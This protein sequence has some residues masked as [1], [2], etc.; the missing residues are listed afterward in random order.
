MPP[1]ITYAIILI[2]FLTCCLSHKGN[3]LKQE[4]VIK[5]KNNAVIN[6]FKQTTCSEMLISI[7]KNMMD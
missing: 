5:K 1:Q 6:S 4:N 2:F 7:M 3:G